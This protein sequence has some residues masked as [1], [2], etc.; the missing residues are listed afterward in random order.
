MNVPSRRFW[1]RSGL[2]LVLAFV[3]IQFV[4]YGCRRGAHLGL[5]RHTGV[6]QADVLRLPQQRNGV[7][8][9][10]VPRHP[11]DSS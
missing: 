3:A 4:P 6:G 11:G 5:A 9:V 7:A 10:R 2:V 1:V 8:G